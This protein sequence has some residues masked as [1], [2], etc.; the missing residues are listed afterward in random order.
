MHEDDFLC[1]YFTLAGGITFKRTSFFFIFNERKDCFLYLN[2]S[3]LKENSIHEEKIDV[4][5][6]LSSEDWKIVDIHN[7]DGRDF[8][9]V[10][11]QLIYCIPI[12]KKIKKVYE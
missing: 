10:N 5:H 12:K 2:V 3:Y 6:K 4:Y 11:G 1:F 8:R 7:E 9:N